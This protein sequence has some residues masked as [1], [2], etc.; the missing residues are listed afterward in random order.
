MSD[1]VETQIVDFL[2]HRL[3]CFS[4]ESEDTQSEDGNE[5]Q[6]ES[7]EENVDD[8]DHMANLMQASTTLR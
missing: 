1:L 7:Q 6:E 4:I 5:T 2:M 3:I 8:E